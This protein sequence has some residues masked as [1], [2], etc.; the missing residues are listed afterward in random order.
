MELNNNE[1][2]KSLPKPGLPLEQPLLHRPVESENVSFNASQS[3]GLQQQ[4]DLTD[5]RAI[6]A[7]AVESRALK[8]LDAQE[9]QETLPLDTPSEGLAL[10]LSPSIQG[11][12]ED[13]P[14]RFQENALDP[15][16]L[17]SLLA[18]IPL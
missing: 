12:L 8:E 17:K 9:G 3:K 13:V 1:E 5:R 11:A 18:P 15:Q 6:E 4:I 2:E 14:N 16:L 10:Q 7:I